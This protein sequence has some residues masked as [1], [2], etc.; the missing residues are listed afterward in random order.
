M[1]N[2]NQKKDINE[3]KKL[4]EEVIRVYSDLEDNLKKTPSYYHSTSETL[5]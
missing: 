2:V 4:N 5:S 3:R 1:R